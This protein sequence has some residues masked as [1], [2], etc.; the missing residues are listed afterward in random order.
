MISASVVSVICFRSSASA[1]P[2]SD[3]NG[4]V[5]STTIEFSCEFCS[6]LAL[7]VGEFPLEFVSAILPDETR[8]GELK[9]VISPEPNFLGLGKPSAP[10][11]KSARDYGMLAAPTALTIGSLGDCAPE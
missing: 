1:L 3:S 8:V 9:G 6:R 10:L 4:K 7:F 2:S 11:R 5:A